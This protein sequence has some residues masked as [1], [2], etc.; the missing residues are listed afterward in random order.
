MTKIRIKTVFLALVAVFVLLPAPDVHGQ[1]DNP[2]SRGEWR[3]AL[4]KCLEKVTERDDYG[5]Y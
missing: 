1:N 3:K 5:I 2:L 4:N